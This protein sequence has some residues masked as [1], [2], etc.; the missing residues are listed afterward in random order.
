MAINYAAKYGKKI[1]Q[2]FELGSLAKS[3]FGAKFD[4]IGV[5]TAKLYTLTSQVLG[6][7]TRT[8][9]SRYGTVN[10]VQ[11][12]VA[13]YTITKDRS[14]TSSIDKGNYLQQNLV[15]TVGAYTKIQ[16][17]EQYIPEVDT[18]AF[19][20]LL[21]SATTATHVK[22]AALTNANVY[23][24]FL[25]LQE[26]L[27]E[28]KVPMK[29]RIAYL[30][31]STCNLIKRDD[32]FVKA[33][34]MAQKML[35]N[36]QIGEI[37]GVKIVKVPSVLFPANTAMILTHPSANGMPQQLSDLKTHEDAPGI[38]GALLEGRWIYDCFTFAQKV[39]A[40]AAHKTA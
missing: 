38:S 4:F 7:Y 23:E 1:D 17:D 36:G 10:E 35:I 31:P 29:G 24:K 2:R 14:F 25:D 22:T 8:G 21:A 40:C 3:A 37:D 18:Y 16:M 19:G 30:T 13:E 12:T 5:N 27:D 9:T 20:V 15:K 26:L 32:T 11:D 6:D 34:D 39:N 33:S 28:D